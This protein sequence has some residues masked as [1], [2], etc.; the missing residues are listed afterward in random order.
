MPPK[1]IYHRLKFLNSRM[2]TN[3]RRGLGPTRLVLLLTT[4]G[5]KSGQPRITPLQYEE[6]DG[7]YYVASARGSEA[8]WFRNIQACPHVHVQ[9][10]DDEFDATAEPITDPERI[11]DFIE[12]RL[13][14][15]PRMIRLIMHLVDGLPLRYSRADLEAL[16]QSKALVILHPNLPDQ[17]LANPLSSHEG[18]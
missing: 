13:E 17:I 15:H 5:R 8:D 9:I 3:Y 2:A 11:A 16:C 14:R 12:L 10:S 4:T 7:A 18:D 6:V 1:T